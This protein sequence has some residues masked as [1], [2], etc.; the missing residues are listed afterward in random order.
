MHRI[1]NQLGWA[2]PDGTKQPE[3]TRRAI[4]A[5]MPRDVWP[6][7]NVLLVGLGQ[8]VQTERGKLLRKCVGCSDPLR[9]LRLAETL[10]VKVAAGLK[11]AG[12]E[13][14]QLPAGYVPGA[15]LNN[16]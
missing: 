3:A 2:G 14:S 7:V 13:G 12:V 1:C 16:E 10:G 11:A 8:E 4:E 6:E 5:W 15:T 9:A